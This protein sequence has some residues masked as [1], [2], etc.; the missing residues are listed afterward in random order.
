MP[1]RFACTVCSAPMSVSSKLAGKLGRCAK[2]KA[3][4]SVPQPGEAGAELTAS[5][6]E[7]PLVNTM[8]VTAHGSPGPHDG[9]E[10]ERIALEM[11]RAKLEMERARLAQAD[12]EKPEERRRVARK[13]VKRSSGLPAALLLGAGAVGAFGF[14]VF[15]AGREPTVLVRPGPNTKMPERSTE[16]TVLDMARNAVRSITG[17]Y[18]VVDVRGDALSKD[19]DAGRRLL[20]TS[21]TLEWGATARGAKVRVIPY[22]DIGDNRLRTGLVGVVIYR[23]EGRNLTLA[24]PEEDV[25]YVLTPR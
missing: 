2:C 20:I 3:T 19:R 5:G 22:E 7:R 13:P 14:L 24:W 25:T 1:I 6:E 21:G 12:A 10:Q 11:E 17:S 8:S 16:P 18:E 15:A 9:L 4:V 23:W